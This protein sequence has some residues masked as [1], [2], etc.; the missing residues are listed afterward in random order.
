M[1]KGKHNHILMSAAT[2][3]LYLQRERRRPAERQGACQRHYCWAHKP[4]MERTETDTESACLEILAQKTRG[5]RT[6]FWFLLQSPPPKKPESAHLCFFFSQFLAL[7][8]TKHE[9]SF[10]DAL[11]RQ[12]GEERMDIKFPRAR[13]LK[14]NRAQCSRHSVPS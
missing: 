5:K 3:T 2:F 13:L 4:T 9:Q 11:W 10:Q 7:L 1:V 14:Q 6:F 8:S 12:N